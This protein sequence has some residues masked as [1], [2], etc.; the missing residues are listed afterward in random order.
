VRNFNRTAS[1]GALLMGLALVG[2][3][4]YEL[5]LYPSAGF[6]T[7]DFAVIVRGAAVLRVGHWL[8]F[9]YAIG[10]ALL[11]VGMHARLKDDA[12]VLAQLAAGALTLRAAEA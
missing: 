1:I 7:Q 4:L 2:Y 12:P 3:A 11:V 10:L 6:P 5:V 9:G 8:K